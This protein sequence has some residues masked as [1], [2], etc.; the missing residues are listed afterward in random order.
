[1][2]P[3]ARRQPLLMARA[4]PRRARAA[5]RPPPRA[6]VEGVGLPSAGLRCPA[7][8]IRVLTEDRPGLVGRA[9]VHD[10]VFDS[11]IVLLQDARERRA[12]ESSLV[13]GRGDDGHERQHENECIKCG[14]NGKSLPTLVYTGAAT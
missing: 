6:L 9:A 11:R 4:C 14:G 5:P 1:M 3:A 8:P 13:E 2:L 7:D 10:E 12:D